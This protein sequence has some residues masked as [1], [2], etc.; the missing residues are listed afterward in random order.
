M[1]EEIMTRE[2]KESGK[3]KGIG[4]SIIS[5]LRE[6]AVTLA[7][8]L[9][10]YLLFTT[11]AFELRS[12]PSESMVPSLQVGDRV[13]VNKFAYGYSRYS[14]PFGL[15]RV[16]PLGEG[17]IMGK[18]PERG[19]VVVFMHPHYPRVMIKRTIGLPGDRVQMISERLYIN[20]EAVSMEY[21]GRRVYRTH[22]APGKPS[23]TV[24]ARTFTETL[25]GGNVHRIEHTSKGNSSDDTYEFI[26][27]EGHILFMGDNRDD[28]LDG[29]A[30]SGHCPDVDGVIATTGCNPLDKLPPVQLVQA[31]I[32]FVPLDHLI[33][34]AETVFFTLNFCRTEEGN[35][36]PPGRVWKPL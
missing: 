22:G 7:I 18:L 15:G 16:L 35:E 10:I 5:E 23:A 17:R 9:P 2:S 1:S 12:I 26:V 32:G 11:F 14:V 25:P 8:F 34:R 33:G 20:G 29:R 27:P 13:A 6:W 19:D 28:S 24:A 3:G 31:S 4:R 36:C 30:L 21:N